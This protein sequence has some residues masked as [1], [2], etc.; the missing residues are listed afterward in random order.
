MIHALDRRRLLSLYATLLGLLLLAAFLTLDSASQINLSLLKLR[1]FT[2][3]FKSAGHHTRR[4]GV[5]VSFEAR[6]FAADAD[7]KTS[8]LDNALSAIIDH[9]KLFR[10][11]QKRDATFLAGFE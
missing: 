4:R 10:R 8:G 7:L 9:R 6:L 3:D 1:H 2:G 5:S 11:Q